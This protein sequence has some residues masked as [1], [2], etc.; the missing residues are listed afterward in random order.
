LLA[1]Y[2]QI[3]LTVDSLFVLAKLSYASGEFALGFNA[4]N[5]Q[6]LS[7]QVRGGAA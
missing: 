1:D 2:S 6:D 3:W 7:G 5:I 4:T